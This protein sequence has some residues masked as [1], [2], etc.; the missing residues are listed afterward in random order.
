MAAVNYNDVASTYDRRY[1]LH[2]YPGT[3][4][5]ILRAIEGVERPRVLEVGCGTGHWLQLLAKRGCEVAG[6]DA[7]AEMLRRAAIAVDG[8]LRHGSAERLPWSDASFDLVLY[9]NA[10]HHF[11]APEAALL[12]AFRVLSTGGR[13][14]S[15]GLDP[16]EQRDRWYVYDYFPTT[17][18]LDRTRF[19]SRDRRRQWFQTAGFTDV[20]VSVAEHLQ[21][22]SSVDDALRDGT[23]A[24]SFTSQLTSLSPGDYADG[25]LR[26]RS[27]ARADPTL[28]LV[29]DLRLYATE[30]TK[31]DS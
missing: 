11:P 4:T 6:L 24:P 20:R 2:D 9:V 17:L 28:R 1:E 19:P 5:T 10:V 31:A 13:V 26:V 27:A 12:E 8:D 7:S 15:I 22:S 16:H 23:L 14:L 21:S 3:G 30:G 25:M 18:P 29:V